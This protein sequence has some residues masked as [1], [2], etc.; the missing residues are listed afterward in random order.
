[1]TGLLPAA[2][3]DARVETLF[4][5]PLGEMM[6]ISPDGQRVAYTSPADGKLAI[7]IMNIEHPDRKRTVPVETDRPA[8]GEEE[9]PPPVQLRFLRWATA[10]RLVYAPVERVLPLPAGT[11]PTGRSVPNPD[12]PTILSPIMAVDADGKQRGT[13]VDAR[14]FQETPAD[15]RRSLADLLRTPRQLEVTRHEP[16]HWRMPHLDILGFHPRDRDQLII[17]TRGAYSIPL[18]HLVDLRVGSIKEFGDAWP[19]P[20]GEP[21]IFDWFRLKVVGERQAGVHPAT[22]WRDEDLARVQRELAAKFPRR[23]V[24]ILDWSDTHARVLFRVTGGSDPG[25]VFVFQRLEDLVLEIL[26]LAPWLTAAKLNPTRWFEFDAADG[27]RLSGYL[28]WP[29]KPRLNPPPLLVVFPSGFPG[30]AQPAFDSEAQVFADLGFAVARLNHRSVGGVN[31]KD[32]P[33]L[34]AAVDRVSV[35][36]ARAVIEWIAARNPARPFD[37][38]RVATLG[39]GFG[40]YLAL[41]ALQLQPMVFRGGIAFDAP[42][43]LQPW[44]R[45]QGTDGVTR[46]TTAGCDIPVALIEHEGTD[47]IKLSV[48]DQAAA[49]TNPVLLLVEPTR[50]PAIDLATDELRARLSRLGR[51]PDHFE[52]EPGWSTARPKSR[53]GAYRKIEEFLNRHLPSYAGKLGPV[54]EVP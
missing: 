49:L 2:S 10:D 46:S 27:G 11:D 5:P 29:A 30:R 1:M 28:T 12:G 22:H 20:P 36:D 47:W 21:Q 23:I 9:Q 18:Q 13:V 14:N 41:R 3:F 42:L 8:T 31:A 4:R 26:H 45:A 16:I 32:V 17:G 35:D 24:E 40:G 15:A 38:Q 7:V 54:T 43:D 44:L 53:V 39:R 52:L 33:A 51:P 37:H 50:N 6:A 19:V 34:R 25:R 48:L